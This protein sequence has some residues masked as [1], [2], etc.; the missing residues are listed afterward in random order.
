M[1]CEKCVNFPHFYSWL[2]T[3]SIPPHFYEHHEPLMVPYNFDMGSAYG[4][5]SGFPG[6][7]LH[8]QQFPI[9]HDTA[10]LH[11]QGPLGSE[12]NLVVANVSESGVPAAQSPAGLSAYSTV[13]KVDRYSVKIGAWIMWMKD[14]FRTVRQRRSYVRCQFQWNIIT[15]TNGQAFVM[16][17]FHL[18]HL[19]FYLSFFFSSVSQL[20]TPRWTSSRKLHSSTEGHEASLRLVEFIKIWFRSHPKN[21]QQ[22]LENETKLLILYN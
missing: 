12:S 22:Q 17:N 1:R 20:D 2:S 11:K 15:Q 14:K 10:A 21:N 3:H 6:N 9:G 4:G 19:H 7:D 13:G 5:P 18:L 16:T 8:P